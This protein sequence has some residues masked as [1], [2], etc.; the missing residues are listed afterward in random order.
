MNIFCNKLKAGV[1]PK[2]PKELKFLLTKYKA[3]NN[4]LYKKLWGKTFVKISHI[5]ER[6]AVLQNMHDGYG[7]FGI[8]A[9][10]KRLYSQYWWPNAYQNVKEYI[11]TFHLCQIY[12]DS[13]PVLP[14]GSV[15]SDY[16]FQ[17]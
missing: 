16:L 8:N 10:W 7:H 1:I 15:P 6:Q 13:N 14:I 4:H 2:G 17:Q 5:T 9:T 3:F 11:K 12:S